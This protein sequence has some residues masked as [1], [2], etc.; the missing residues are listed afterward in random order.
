MVTNRPAVDAGLAL[1][2]AGGDFA[3]GVIAYEGAWLGGETF[4][5]FDK[6][7]VTSLSEL[8]E[9]IRNSYPDWWCTLLGTGRR[10]VA[11]PAFSPYSPRRSERSAAR[12]AHQSGGLGV[13]SSNLGA[14]TS[15]IKDLAENFRGDSPQHHQLG[16]AGGD[17]QTGSFS[18][19]R[20]Q[21]RHR[22]SRGAPVKTGIDGVA[23]CQ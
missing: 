12:L 23:H 7:A 20:D 11:Q 5:S 1:L 18:P 6:A 22:L 4:V 2:E 19:V 10:K 21:R 13:P 9:R 3:D 17:L 15:K 8:G 16:R 14:P